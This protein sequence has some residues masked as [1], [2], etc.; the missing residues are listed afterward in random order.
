MLHAQPVQLKW[1]ISLASA[2]FF[3]NHFVVLSAGRFDYGYNMRANVATG[4]LGSTGWMAWYFL[5]P[6]RSPYAWKMCVLQLL[7]A[8]ALLLELLDF[9]PVWWTFDAHALW[10]LMTVPLTWLLYR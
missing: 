10:H 4:L 2:L 8:A 1:F 9:A 5:Q 3:V 7:A 6:R